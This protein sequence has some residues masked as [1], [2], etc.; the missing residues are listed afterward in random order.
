MGAQTCLLPSRLE[1][2]RSVRASDCRP[3]NFTG[4]CAWRSD[5]AALA[6]Y[7]RRSGFTPCPED[8]LSLAQLRSA[9]V[10]VLA[11]IGW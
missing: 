6:G 7:D 4:S 3:R 2:E 11:A 5:L 8:Q 1:V 10:K 9:L